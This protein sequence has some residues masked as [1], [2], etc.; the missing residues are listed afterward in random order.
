MD[1]WLDVDALD[2][3]M[4]AYFAACDQELRLYLA[5]CDRETNR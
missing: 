1:A 2:R 4:A 5:A 3:E